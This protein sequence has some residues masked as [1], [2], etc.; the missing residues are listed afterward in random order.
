M[1]LCHHAR[2]DRVLPR[3]VAAPSATV[4]VPG[5]QQIA[6][7]GLLNCTELGLAPGLQDLL[8]K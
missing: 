1:C 8:T 3:S 2:E 7:G 4:R 5:T 6:T